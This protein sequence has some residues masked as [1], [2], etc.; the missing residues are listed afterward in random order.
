[1]LKKIG[2]GVLA[3]VLVLVILIS[4]RPATFRIERSAT[5][6]APAEVVFYFLN[7]FHNWSAWSP[8]EKLDSKMKK[9]Y[10][11]ARA[12]VGAIYRWEGNDQVGEGR[13]TLTESKP[14]EQ[15]A[16]KLEF[17]KPFAATNETTFTLKPA[18]G[19]VNVTW[20]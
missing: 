16:I 8:W 19:G 7:D 6:A 18:T 3:V 9:A 4:T 12:G 13:M 15:V 1:M 5:I 10:E 20:A 2:L 17:L 11:G 14:H